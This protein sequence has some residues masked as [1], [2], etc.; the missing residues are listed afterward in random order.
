MWHSGFD[1]LQQVDWVQWCIP[2]VPETE[3]REG[4]RTTKVILDSWVKFRTA[5]L[6]WSLVWMGG[7]GE[8]GW[9]SVKLKQLYQGLNF[10]GVYIHFLCLK[11][12]IS[13]TLPGLESEVILLPPSLECQNYRHVLLTTLS[14]LPGLSRNS[15]LQI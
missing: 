9:G 10:G 12:L 8:G 11:Q 2:A 13:E 1:V 7:E 4:D 5:L 14:H 15:N 3:W 6:I